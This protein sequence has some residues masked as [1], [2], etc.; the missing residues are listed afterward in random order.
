MGIVNVITRRTTS[1][2]ALQSE[3]SHDLVGPRQ[4]AVLSRALDLAD[5]VVLAH[6]SGPR[7]PVLKA[8]F[9]RSRDALHAELRSRRRR[10]GLQV[11]TVGAAEVHPRRWNFGPA[12]SPNESSPGRLRTSFAST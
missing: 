5:V 10:Q 7:T 4:R 9:E 8:T 3:P 6:G 1:L 12:L 11:A 2:V